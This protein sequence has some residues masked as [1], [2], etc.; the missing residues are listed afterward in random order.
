MPTGIV[1][2]R[3]AT[4]LSPHCGDNRLDCAQACLVIAGTRRESAEYTCHF[5]HR[6]EVEV[7]IGGTRYGTSNEVT[8]TYVP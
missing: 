8:F 2:A 1:R 3:R 6:L 5:S 7:Q 4:K